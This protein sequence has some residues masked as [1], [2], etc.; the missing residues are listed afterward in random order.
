MAVHMEKSGT[1]LQALLSTARQLVDEV[2]WTLFRRRSP[3][4]APRPPAL[5]GPVH[6]QPLHRLLV[7]DGVG[8]T[9]FEEFAAHRADAK[10]EEETGWVLLGLRSNT[11][12]VA[13]ATLPAGAKS[14]ASIA[15]VRFNSLGQ[16]LGS[17][18][19]RQH[20]KR[21]TILGVVHTHPGS[22]RHPSEGDFRGDSEWVSHLRGQ[23][24]VF[25]IG[26]ADAVEH[27][28]SLFA[29]QPRSH[30]Q[31]LADMCLSWYALRQ[32]DVRYR[33]LPVDMTLGPDLARPLHN[34]WG[35]VEA[36]AERL[37]RLFKQ[38]AGVT[39]EVGEGRTGPALFVNVPLSEPDRAV[40]VSLTQSEVKYFIQHAEELLEIES[41]DDRVD[42]GVYLLLA[43]L[44]AKP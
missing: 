15:H 33:P 6:Y 12:A 18:I 19:V 24:G 34:I 23:E 40:R 37:E 41:P 9:L 4:P 22:L 1:M 3:A 26:T 44:A 35:A 28:E 7:T 31:C 8:R 36:H 17:R 38:Q 16:A 14:D 32:G 30:V 11:E 10:G 42:R 29:E 43:E 5:S 20:D 39:F 21:L 2:S 13:L 25:G 27:A